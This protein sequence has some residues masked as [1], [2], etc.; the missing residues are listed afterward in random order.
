MHSSDLTLQC[1]HDAILWI[2]T[3]TRFHCS[4]ALFCLPSSG[5]PRLLVLWVLSWSHRCPSDNTNTFII[6]YE[7]SCVRYRQSENLKLIQ[8]MAPQKYKTFN[9]NKQHIK[10][11]VLLYSLTGR[12]M[13]YWITFLSLLIVY[14]FINSIELNWQHNW[15]K[16]IARTTSICVWGNPQYYQQRESSTL[17]PFFM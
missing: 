4:P 9:K 8:E 15:A 7:H 2:V 1:T 16:L 5:L 14:L 13:T 3:E 10:E 12:I 11:T 17:F 6:S